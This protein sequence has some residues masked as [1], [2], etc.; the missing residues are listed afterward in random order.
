M[1]DLIRGAID[2][3]SSQREGALATQSKKQPGF[4]F[5]SSA[6]LTV[7]PDG[8]PAFLFSGLATHT[9]NLSADPRASLLVTTTSDKP[10]GADS[11]LTLIGNLE[12]VSDAHLKTVAKSYLEAHPAAQQ[13]ISFGDFRFYQ[14]AI[15]DI[16][17]VAGFGDMGWIKPDAFQSAWQQSD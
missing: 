13:W 14:L 10:G 2:L 17:F 4:P 7:T 11:R 9:K 3:L 12:F 5:V 8:Y 6:P 15:V 16:Y 1:S